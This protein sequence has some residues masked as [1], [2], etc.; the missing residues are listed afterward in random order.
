MSLTFFYGSCSTGMQ[1]K[2]NHQIFWYLLCGN[3]CMH[4]CGINWIYFL[5]F[6][7]SK[8]HVIVQLPTSKSISDFLMLVLYEYK[9][10]EWPLMNFKSTWMHFLEVALKKKIKKNHINKLIRFNVCLHKILWFL[11]SIFQLH[12]NAYNIHNWRITSSSDDSFQIQCTE[13]YLKIMFVF[14]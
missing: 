2:W 7:R 6:F 12:I 1:Q 5:Y 11:F 8:A 14:I 13:F 4:A 10:Q 3:I 9:R